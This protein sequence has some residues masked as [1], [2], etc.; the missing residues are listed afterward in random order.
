[1]YHDLVYALD[2]IQ[3]DK[4]R[5][6]VRKDQGEEGD[7]HWG[8]VPRQKVVLEKDYDKGGG[9]E[10][11]RS[12]DHL[13]YRTRGGGWCVCEQHRGRKND[14]QLRGLS[15]HGGSIYEMGNLEPCSCAYEDALQISKWRCQEDSWTKNLELMREMRTGDTTL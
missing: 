12:G 2:K 6:D 9:E 15:M 13:R 10:W 1:M 4:Q 5:K 7:Q 3:A 14:S 11:F 8:R